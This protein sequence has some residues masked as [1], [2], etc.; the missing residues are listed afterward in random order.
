MENAK[1]ILKRL[2]ADKADD[3]DKKRLGE[4]VRLAQGSDLWEI[5]TAIINMEIAGVLDDVNKAG[6]RPSAM[7]AE[8]IVGHL[9]GL[10]KVQ[11]RLNQLVQMELEIKA[12]D[13]LSRSK[14]AEYEPREYP[15]PTG[16]EA[17][18]SGD[19]DA[20]IA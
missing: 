5:L 10:R 13:R 14:A 16:W 2:W 4:F 6:L 11:D 15:G 20:M 1:T 3:R 18:K 12:R 17:E 9:C 19:P 8:Q 7:P